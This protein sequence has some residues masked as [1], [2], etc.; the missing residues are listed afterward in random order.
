MSKEVSMAINTNFAAKS[1]SRV[2]EL[3]TKLHNLIKGSLSVEVYVQAIRAIGDEL[4]TCGNPMTK[5]SLTLAL[6]RGLGPQ[7]KAFYAST[8]QLLENLTFDDVTANLNIFYLHLS[9]QVTEQ[10]PSKFPPTANYAHT[11]P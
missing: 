9:R 3:Q 1:R 6:L 7:Y 5:N 2:M 10:V 8:S 11:H 4:Q